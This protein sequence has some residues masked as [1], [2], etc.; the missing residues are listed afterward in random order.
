MGGPRSGGSALL[1][2]GSS[3]P[4]EYKTTPIWKYNQK[5]PSVPANEG[6]K[7]SGDRPR[8]LV[9]QGVAAG[10]ATC[11]PAQGVQ[12]QGTLGSEA[13]CAITSSESLPRQS[14][15]SRQMAAMPQPTSRKQRKKLALAKKRDNLCI[16]TRLS[17]SG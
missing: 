13:T 3:V 2:A 12:A 5:R 11:D 8:D 4:G 10:M 17:V 14:E 1:V 15:P 7:I 9:M 16:D 6:A